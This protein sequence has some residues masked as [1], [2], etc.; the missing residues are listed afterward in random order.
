MKDDWER[1]ALQ[2]YTGNGKGKSTAAFG[3]ALRASG[4]GMR[5]YIGQ[6]MKGQNYGELHSV[7][8]LE[9]VDLEQYGDPGWCYKGK[10]TESQRAQ[11]QAGLEKGLAALEGGR[12]DIVI[13]D[14]LNMALWFELVN[15]SQVLDLIRRRPRMTELV[16][17]GRN[18]APAVI[19]LAD[20][21]T[22]MKEIKHPYAAGI[23]A[24]KG[25]EH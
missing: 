11:A 7:N 19:E 5:V 18:A 2:V 17:T 12:Y 13:L 22:E 20:L 21:V 15:E 10:I 23:Q 24:R 9:G 1:G 6:F 4:R 3:L 25:I 16:L 8:W 14:E